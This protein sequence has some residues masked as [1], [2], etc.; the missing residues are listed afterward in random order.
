MES[1]KVCLS[2]AYVDLRD[3]GQ[4]TATETAHNS[5]VVVSIAFH[6]LSLLN[7]LLINTS[8]HTH[9]HTCKRT[10]THSISQVFG[11]NMQLY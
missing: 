2:G 8:T 3:G 1:G 10:D 9:A 6:D 5:P 4:I 11:M 7:F